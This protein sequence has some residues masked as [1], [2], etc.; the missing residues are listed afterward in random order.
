MSSDMSGNI[1]EGR[2][3]NAYVAYSFRS[4]RNNI[5]NDT[6]KELVDLSSS[7]KYLQCKDISFGVN[8]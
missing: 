4:A 6:C 8:L 2:T 3:V 5:D 7:F 1:N